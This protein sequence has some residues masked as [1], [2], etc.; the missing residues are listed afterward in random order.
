MTR[1]RT[2]TASCNRSYQRQHYSINA[3]PPVDIR[4]GR[5]DSSPARLAMSN[6]YAAGFI[7]SA[8]FIPKVV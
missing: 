4:K 8:G 5:S 2:G 1:G 6:L 7:F 3:F